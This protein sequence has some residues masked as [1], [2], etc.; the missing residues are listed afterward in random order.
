MG[1]HAITVDIAAPRE[2][3]FDLFVNLERAPEWIEGMAGVSDKHELQPGDYKAV[4]TAGDESLTVP[5][6]VAVRQDVALRVVI[7]DDKLAVER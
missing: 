4:L 1:R 2:Q 3:V 6:S 7:K 5:V